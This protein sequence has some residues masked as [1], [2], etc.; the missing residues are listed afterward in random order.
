MIYNKILE[1][2]RISAF[3][4]TAVGGV[5]R[6]PSFP[7]SKGCGDTGFFYKER[8]WRSS[9]TRTLIPS[10][11]SIESAINTKVPYPPFVK[12]KKNREKRK[13]EDKANFCLISSFFVK[14]CQKSPDFRVY[15]DT[16]FFIYH[17]SWIRDWGQNP[18]LWNPVP[19]PLNKEF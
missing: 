4:Q 8:G 2:R 6:H 19:N 13:K 12:K 3:V 9:E 14:I 1:K 15:G 7:P 17:G 10:P 16:G 18:D 11:L 5:V